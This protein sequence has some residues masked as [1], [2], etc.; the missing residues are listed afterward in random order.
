M[1]FADIP[2]GA[3]VFLDTNAPIYHFAAHPQYG[4]ACT[5]LRSGSSRESF[6]VSL[7]PR[8]G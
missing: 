3:A 6:K 1:T 5:R 8:P 7:L 2:A 4:T